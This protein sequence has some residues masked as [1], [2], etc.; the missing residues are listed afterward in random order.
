MQCAVDVLEEEVQA[1]HRRY[2][3]NADGDGLC[4][5]E[6][7]VE[8]PTRGVAEVEHVGSPIDRDEHRE[9]PEHRQQHVLDEMESPR[10]RDG[11]FVDVLAL[12][13]GCQPAGD[14]GDGEDARQL[15]DPPDEQL[16]AEQRVA[17]P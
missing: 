9:H 8:N 2:G 15:H 13:I 17:Q 7:R 10:I 5:N 4:L 11:F 16:H 14:T 1:N 6:L 12:L 3:R